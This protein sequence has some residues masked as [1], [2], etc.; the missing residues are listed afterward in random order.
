M[1]QQ[2]QADI[3]ALKRTVAKLDHTTIAGFNRTDSRG[4]VAFS[5]GSRPEFT[6][7]PF[8]TV[9]IVAK[10][11]VTDA[12]LIV[13]EAKYADLPPLPCGKVG[14]NTVCH[15]GWFGD[16]FQVHPP[17][18]KEAIDYDGDEYVEGSDDAPP[19]LDTVFH[20]CHREHEVWVL[21]DKGGGAALEP[22]VILG[23]TNGLPTGKFLNVKRAVYRTS[24]QR[25]IADPSTEPSATMVVETWHN[26]TARDYQSFVGLNPPLIAAMTKVGDTTRVL[27]N[28]ANIRWFLTTAT[29]TYAQSDCPT[30]VP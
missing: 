14:E 22:I 21:D 2:I 3:A 18:G 26:H 29:G 12:T 4:G 20:R 28:G 27:S 25:W 10:P 23:S 15:Y 7:L 19:K 11:K 24:D 16:T 30:G 1:L 6:R 9:V 17:L 13:R 8:K 5:D